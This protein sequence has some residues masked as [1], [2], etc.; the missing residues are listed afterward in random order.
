M[1]SGSGPISGEGSQEWMQMRG[2]ASLE[3]LNLITAR[4]LRPS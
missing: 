3:P 2:R 1:S 4:V